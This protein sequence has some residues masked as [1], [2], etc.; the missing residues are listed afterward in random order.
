[1]DNT[2]NVDP[3][4]VRDTYYYDRDYRIGING[5]LGGN[6]DITNHLIISIESFL[7]VA[8]RDELYSDKEYRNGR[9]TLDSGVKIQRVL[10]QIQP[11]SAINL[12]Y[13]F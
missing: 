2:G 13:K 6:Y 3:P 12:I 10:S 4:L 11:V 7:Q 1:M 8:Y 5:V 9:M